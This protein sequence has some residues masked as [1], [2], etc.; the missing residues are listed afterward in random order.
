MILAK[1]GKSTLIKSKGDF[2]SMVSPHGRNKKNNL[3][4]D[5]FRIGHN[6]KRI[7]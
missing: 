3:L 7:K 4:F 6:D 2:S 5:P 1:V